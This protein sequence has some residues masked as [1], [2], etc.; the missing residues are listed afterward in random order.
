MDIHIAQGH[1]PP[2]NIHGITVI[3]DVIRAFTTSHHAFKG[4]LRCIW[5]VE[6]AEQAFLLQ[7]QKPHT[8]LAGEVKAL[9]IKGFDFGNSPWEMDQADLCGKELILRTTNGVAATLRAKDSQQVLVAGL[10][11]ARATAN[12][13]RQ[14]NPPT[15]VLVASHPT[16]DEDV[17]CAE[18]IRY[19]LGGDGITLEQ[20]R[21]R[22]VN[23]RAAQKFLDGSHPRL[24]AED[25][26]FAGRCAGDDALVM[27][28]T[29]TPRPC[30][31]VLHNTEGNR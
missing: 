9:P 26:A 8:L 20:A 15:V 19:L 27:G 1:N 28:V 17:A 24:R 4:G 18:H 30:I 16:G 12:Y 10:V 14:K 3:I 6:N 31:T 25:I 21:Q 29:F 23:A 22:T 2:H 13:I 5:P 11:N 7:Q